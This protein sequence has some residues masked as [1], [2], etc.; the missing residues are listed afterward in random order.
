MKIKGN[1]TSDES[2]IL[3]RKLWEESV[4]KS[5]DEVQKAGV[6]IYYPDKA[7]FAE[8]VSGVYESYKDNPTIYSYIKR[9][10][11]TK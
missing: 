5:L 11:A 3:E 10:Q 9:I 6:K 1:I 2:V 4:K 7:A 8:K